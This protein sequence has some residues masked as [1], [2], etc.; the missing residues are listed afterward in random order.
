VG[1]HHKYV[2]VL[3]EI[4]KGRRLKS[5]EQ[6]SHNRSKEHGENVDGGGGGGGLACLWVK[7]E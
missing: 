2:D 3:P 6:R 5:T 1:Y 7:R 4:R